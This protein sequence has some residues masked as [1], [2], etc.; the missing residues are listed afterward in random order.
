[1]KLIK[2]TDNLIEIMTEFFNS[3]GDNIKDYVTDIRSVVLI[4]L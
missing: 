2:I 4:Q 3:R 1:M